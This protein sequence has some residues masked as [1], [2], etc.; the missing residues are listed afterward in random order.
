MCDE[1]ADGTLRPGMAAAVKSLVLLRAHDGYGEWLRYG[2][3]D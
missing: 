3:M 1:R 2:W